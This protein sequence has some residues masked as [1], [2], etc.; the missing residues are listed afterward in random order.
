MWMVITMPSL[1]MMLMVHLTYG[2]ITWQ[3]DTTTLPIPLFAACTGVNQAHSIMYILGGNTVNYPHSEMYQFNG[4][5]SKD[6]GNL[7]WLYWNCWSQSI[8]VDD[9]IYAIYMNDSWY[10]L[11]L[12]TYDIISGKMTSI[13]VPEINTTDHD[14]ITDLGQCLASNSTHLFM[15]GSGNCTS[16]ACDNLQIYNIENGYWVDNDKLGKSPM[17]V[18]NAACVYYDYFLYVFGG[19]WC[20]ATNIDCDEVSNGTMGYNL[21]SNTWVILEAQLHN[22]WYGIWGAQAIMPNHDG[23]IYILAGADEL[24]SGIDAV[25][26]FNA[27]SQ[28]M[29]SYPPLAYPITQAMVGFIKG[30]IYILGGRNINRLEGTSSIQYSSIIQTASPT[31]APTKITESPTKSPSRYPSKSPSKSPS[32][33]PTK[34]PSKSPSTSP[35]KSP[36]RSPTTKSPSRSPTRSPSRSPTMPSLAPTNSPS[37]MPPTSSSDMVHFAI[38]EQ[39]LIYVSCGLMILLMCFCI[40]F[41]CYKR[42]R[43]SN[44]LIDAYAMEGRVSLAGISAPARI[45]GHNIMDTSEE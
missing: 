1:F 22:K 26:M 33:S 34:S 25:N 45:H 43:D 23:L 5:H 14:A 2:I 24:N 41:R 36:S 9:S 8:T 17:F 16:G 32:R 27:S 12:Q 40:G 11:Y 35:T 42:K 28:L 38:S 18:R 20:P 15:I 7:P 30:R 37:S 6:N 13:S 44:Q 29:V 19:M 21:T 10:D 3:N 31:H 39:A 4:T